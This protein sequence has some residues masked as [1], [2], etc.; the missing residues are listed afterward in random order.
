[1]M[2]KPGERALEAIK[3]MDNAIVEFKMPKVPTAKKGQM[4][5]LT[6]EHYVEV[7][8]SHLTFHFILF[9]FAISFAL[10]SKIGTW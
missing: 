9:I 3:K 6:E 4:K 2:E 5:I 1:M 10:P 7:K 8:Y